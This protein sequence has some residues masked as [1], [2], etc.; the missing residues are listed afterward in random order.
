MQDGSIA[1]TWRLTKYEARGADGSVSS[2]L[3][4]DADG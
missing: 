3:G 1:G 2:P 4:P